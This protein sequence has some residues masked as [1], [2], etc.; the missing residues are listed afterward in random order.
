MSPSAISCL[1]G[2]D[3][4]VSFRTDSFSSESEDSRA[5]GHAQRSATSTMSEFAR[6]KAVKLF[7]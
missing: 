1:S 7:L 2:G 3:S 5:A 6:R 4:F